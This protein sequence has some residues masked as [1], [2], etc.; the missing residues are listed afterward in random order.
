M[1]RVKGTKVLDADRDGSVPTATGGGGKSALRGIA[2]LNPLR[3]PLP[4]LV[5]TSFGAAYLTGRSRPIPEDALQCYGEIW[6]LSLEGWDE[7]GSPTDFIPSYADG[8]T[9]LGQWYGHARNEAKIALKY[10]HQPT[11][12][13]TSASFL[14]YNE[15]VFFAIANLTC[16]FNVTNLLFYNQAFMTLNE[17]APRRRAKA[18][19]L[20]D[21]INAVPTWTLIRNHA[22]FCGSIFG[23]VHNVPFMRVWT[24]ST[25]DWYGPSQAY[26]AQTTVYPDELF[27]SLTNLDNWLDNIESAIEVAEGHLNSALGANDVEDCL[28]IRDLIDM[29]RDITPGVFEAG[30]LPNPKDLPGLTTSP[31][32]KSELY[33]RGSMWKDSFGLGTD[34]RCAFPVIGE[35]N[36]RDQV[37]IGIWGEIN[38][39]YAYTLLG[40][41]KVFKLNDTDGLYATATG[42]AQI[43]YGTDHPLDYTRDFTYYTRLGGWAQADAFIDYGDGGALRTLSNLQLPLEENIFAPSMFFIPQYEITDGA[44]TTLFNFLDKIVTCDKLIYIEPEDLGENY[45]F[46]LSRS[47]NVPYL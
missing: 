9:L 21:R 13:N 41:S 37:P 39:A 43:K 33:G 45:A 22:I 25:V 11:A 30:K 3:A 2:D 36:F 4:E 29:V 44:G 47:L 26:T 27:T 19:R 12:L 5:K 31:T 16:F 42:N 20:W 6:K 24:E 40:A 32:L 35:S 8:N 38:E 15:P 17:F 18:S 7:S 14:K 1:R 10:K 23:D 46:L 28:G 34:L